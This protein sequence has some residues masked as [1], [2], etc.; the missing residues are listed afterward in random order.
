MEWHHYK[1]RLHQW[2]HVVA[3]R[4]GAAGNI[5][6]AIL[7][8]IKAFSPKDI[9]CIRK[10]SHDTT[11][12]TT[13]HMMQR[14]APSERRF[15]PCHQSPPLLC[16]LHSGCRAPDQ[17]EHSPGP[18]PHSQ[19]GSLTP[20]IEGMSEGQGRNRHIMVNRLESGMRRKR[21]KEREEWRVNRNESCRLILCD[22]TS[23]RSQNR[24]GQVFNASQNINIRLL[25]I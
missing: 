23:T 14:R 20:L 10:P 24:Q 22:W 19:C 21:R 8:R 2:N 17:T 13:C 6:T 7:K 4:H 5:L 18:P 16:V 11:H 3:V 1:A 12:P 25:Q 15:A 9:T